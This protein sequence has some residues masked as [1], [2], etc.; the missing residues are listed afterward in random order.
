MYF[1]TITRTLQEDKNARYLLGFG[2]VSR[3][4]ELKD[5]IDQL[6]TAGLINRWESPK[7]RASH[8]YLAIWTGKL[9]SLASRSV[10]TDQPVFFKPQ[11]LETFCSTTVGLHVKNGVRLLNHLLDFAGDAVRARLVK[12]PRVILTESK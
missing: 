11:K 9:A 2:G 1:V 5:S 3:F 6:I 7:G 10:G 4:E 12:D 8:V